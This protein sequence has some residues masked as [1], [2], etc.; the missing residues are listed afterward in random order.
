MTT[1][2][3]RPHPRLRIEPTRGWAGLKLGEV[4]SHRELLYFLT[5]RDVKIR[6]RQTVFGALWAVLQPFLLMVVFAVFLG[7]LVGVPSEGV[8]YPLFAY[9]GLV[10]WTL[11]AQSVRGCSESLVRN[12]NLVSKIYFPRLLLPLSVTASFVLDF[13]IASALLILLMIYYDVRPSV[14]VLWLPAITLL[15]LATT[16]AI[17]IWLAA[18]NARYR[19]V[20]HA[21]PF[22]V[23]V[24]L[25]LTPVAYPASL[26]PEE[27][28]LVYAL[29]PMAGAVEGFRW[30]V[31]GTG[32]A[33]SA[34][35]AVSGAVVVIGLVLGLVYFRSV[36]RTMADVI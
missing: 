25:F 3:A 8:A 10:P 19:D 21:V 27:W 16:M 28:R 22:L 26:V 31:L 29:N 11:F 5:W 34:T 35:L 18:L 7:R 6:Y 1:R 2:P 14:D 33:P 24:W 4:W 23:Q 12:S 9:T 15:I 20:Q 30:S 13:V 36:D 32:T 17:G